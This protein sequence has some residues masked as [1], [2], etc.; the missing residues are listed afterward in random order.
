MSQRRNLAAFT[1]ATNEPYPAYASLNEE[2]DG[3]VTLTV[4]ERGH[5]G[6]KTATI[7][8]DRDQLEKFLAEGR[9][10]LQG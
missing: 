10:N 9:T 2:A 5:E 3:A 6:N 1:E 4:R 8:L 7:T